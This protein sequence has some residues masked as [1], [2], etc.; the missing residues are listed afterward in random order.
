MTKNSIEQKIINILTNEADKMCECTA[1]FFIVEKTVNHDQIKQ[2]SQKIVTL[3]FEDN[4]N[5]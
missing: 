3:F 1:P 4:K 2:V 5:D